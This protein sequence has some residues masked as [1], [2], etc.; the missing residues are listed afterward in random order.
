MKPSEILKKSHWCKR[1]MA[2]N[3]DGRVVPCES[4]KACSFCAMGAMFASCW[5][6]ES[7]DRIYN[8]FSKIIYAKYGI[9]SVVEY[10]DYICCNK[11]ELIALFEEIGE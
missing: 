6:K 1:V 5:K 11:E 4:P 9:G 7:I 3:N 10:N 2:L 8:K